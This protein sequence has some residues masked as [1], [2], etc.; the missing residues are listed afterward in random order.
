MPK[1]SVEQFNQ[2]MTSEL[3]WGAEAGLLLE[4]IEYGKAV[5]RLPYR[6]NSTRP[7]GTISGPHMMT[8]ADANMF[9]VVLSMIGEVKLAVTTSFNINFLRKP[10]ETDLVG[11]GSI[12]KLGKRL[13]VI[14]VSI[15]SDDDIVA[16][17]TGTYSIPPQP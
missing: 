14:E 11:V 2:I 10:Q 3:P 6:K 15:Y 8:L 7:G 1:V 13:A 16:H 4:S 9:A 17:A 5:M 12:I